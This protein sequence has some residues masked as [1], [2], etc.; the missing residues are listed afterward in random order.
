MGSVIQIL[1]SIGVCCGFFICYGTVKIPS[2]LAWRL[3][4]VIQATLAVILAICCPTLPGSPRWMIAKGRY[5]EAYATLDRL[6]L[7]RT[8]FEDDP[9]A[10]PPATDKDP[11]SGT[12]FLT[13]FQKGY[14]KQTF[15]AVFLMA[16]C[17]CS[18]IDGVLYVSLPPSRPPVRLSC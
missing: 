7:S 3:P 10:T 14:R 12:R 6:G 15:L 5:A 16:M 4:S 11:Q 9:T 8:E 17:Q 1:I 18:G 13:V 2:S